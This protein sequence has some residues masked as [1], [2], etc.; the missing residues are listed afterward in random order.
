[1][2]T[3][4]CIPRV[5]RGEHASFGSMTASLSNKLSKT[6][7]TLLPRHLSIVLSPHGYPSKC[8]IY[9][10]RE[11]WYPNTYTTEYD[12]EKQK[13]H[14]K[15]QRENSR[16]T[17]WRESGR[18]GTNQ[19]IMVGKL[20]LQLASMFDRFLASFKDSSIAL[21]RVM[22]VSIVGLSLVVNGVMRD[23]AHVGAM[24]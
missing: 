6:P 20:E 15:V 12:H 7:G 17:D 16:L 10:P 22:S 18:P 14:Q 1:M 19:Y 2:R 3:F 4:R 13:S 8:T 9:H 11:T 21:W 24:P 23:K 5:H